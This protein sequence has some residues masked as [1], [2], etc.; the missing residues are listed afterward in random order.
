MWPCSQLCRAITF[1]DATIIGALPSPLIQGM[2]CSF[3]HDDAPDNPVYST[4]TSFG[5]VRLGWVQFLHSTPR[6]GSLLTCRAALSCLLK[7]A[8][9]SFLASERESPHREHEI[10]LPCAGYTGTVFADCTVHPAMALCAEDNDESFQGLDWKIS[11][12]SGVRRL[13]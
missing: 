11:P 13:A 4:N 12:C 5:A 3:G 9:P 10:P 1:R 6:V 8:S 2:T 7:C